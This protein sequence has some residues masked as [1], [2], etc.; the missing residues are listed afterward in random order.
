MS[1]N[2]PNR[3]GLLTHLAGGHTLI[4][5]GSTDR[6]LVDALVAAGVPRRQFVLAY[7]SEDGPDAA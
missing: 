1:A 7:T 6:P 2:E 5:H 3:T 4:E